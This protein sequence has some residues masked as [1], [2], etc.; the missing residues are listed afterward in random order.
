MSTLAPQADAL[1]APPISRRPGRNAQGVRLIKLDDGDRLV[2]MA[3]IDVAEAVA[4][5]ETPPES[6]DGNGDPAPPA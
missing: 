3:R 4:E 5:S 2:A 1:T 6:T